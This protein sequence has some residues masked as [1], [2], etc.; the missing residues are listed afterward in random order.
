MALLMGDVMICP[1]VYFAVVDTAQQRD[2]HST[3]DKNK[4]NS[5]GYGVVWQYPVL[6]R[7]LGGMNTRGSSPRGRE[8][9]TH[10]GSVSAACCGFTLIVDF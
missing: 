8:V 3:C 10:N 4:S 9:Y 2:V 1:L 7:L 5:R 6:V